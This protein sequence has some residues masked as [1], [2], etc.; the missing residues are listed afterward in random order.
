MNIRSSKDLDEVWNDIR[1]GKNIIL[2][3][4]RLKEVTLKT[5]KRKQRANDSED[6]FD[7]DADIGKKKKKVAEVR[8]RKVDETVEK[9]REKHGISFTQMQYHIWS[10]MIV[11]NV[12]SGID[13]PPCLRGL[14]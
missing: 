7:E 9:L 13:L 1:Q 2:W 4:D 14:V 11:G 12:H 8:E 6:D 10:E 3:C 5:R